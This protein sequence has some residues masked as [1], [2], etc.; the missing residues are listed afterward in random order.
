MDD[1][2]GILTSPTLIRPAITVR[3]ESIQGEW[4]LVFKV[5]AARWTAILAIEVEAALSSLTESSAKAFTGRELGALVEQRLMRTGSLAVIVEP[6][7]FYYGDGSM[8]ARYNYIVE[9]VDAT[10]EPLALELSR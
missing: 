8:M 3:M 5:W 4:T 7:G 1:R 2:G 10:G 9:T 6:I